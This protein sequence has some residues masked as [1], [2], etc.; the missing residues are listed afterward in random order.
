MYE[1][2][3]SLSL[4]KGVWYGSDSDRLLQ[5]MDYYVSQL[6]QNNALL[7]ENVRKMMEASERA[8]RK[9]RK[10][11][12]NEIVSITENGEIIFVRMYDDGSREA[13][14]FIVNLTGEPVFYRA[15]FKGYTLPDDYSAVYFR[16]Q[17]IWIFQKEK[18]IS[19]GKLFHNFILSGV[20][21]GSEIPESTIKRLLFSSFGVRMKN[22]ENQIEIPALAG[23]YDG[24]FW[25]RESIPSEFK[26][27]MPSLPI[28]EKSFL[29][30]QMDGN[31]WECYFRE[32]RQIAHWE[33]RLIVMLYPVAALMSSLLKENHLPL[34]IGVNFVLMEKFSVK[35]ICYWFQIFNRD[36]YKYLR[37]LTCN[38]LQK[39]VSVHK[40]DIV[41]YDMETYPSDSYYQ[42]S[43]PLK[44]FMTLF[45]YLEEG[46]LL[47]GLAGISNNI[48]LHSNI[49]NLFLDENF[50]NEAISV[51]DNDV[52]GV[53]LSAFVEYAEQN[54]RMVS[55]KV[56]GSPGCGNTGIFQVVLEILNEFWKTEGIDFRKAADLPNNIDFDELFRKKQFLPD[57]LLEHFRLKMRKSA[58]EQFF[59]K[60]NNANNKNSILYDADYLWIP[61]G[62]FFEILQLQGMA[63]YKAQILLQLREAGKLE[64]DGHGMSKRV[65]CSGVSEEYY[66]IERSFF[67]AFDIADIVDLGKENG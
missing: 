13:F 27:D 5:S 29:H 42:R 45:R 39:E 26:G 18:S 41:I 48:V 25:S 64:T 12:T 6:G 51:T 3:E 43:E 60:K 46:T 38:A 1:N 14:P 35:K 57:D 53:F 52:V 40:D 56:K 7:L 66:K 8:N 55:Q 32:M 15:K 19:A 4:Q 47:A 54:I 34:D 16:C 24:K 10:C 31:L 61:T 21:F 28:M 67:N 36:H 58:P 20:R 62:L 30:F 2:N 65:Q 17:N 59:E 33:D 44:R 11:K 9:K 37:G 23:W 49:V 63:V 50:C 22:A